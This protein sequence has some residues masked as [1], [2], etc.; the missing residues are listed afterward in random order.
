MNT[1]NLIHATVA[2]VSL[3]LSAAEPSPFIGCCADLTTDEFNDRE[4]T[5]EM[6]TRAGIGIV[7]TGFD[8]REAPVRDGRRD[9][10]RWD[11][12]LES[13]RRARMEILAVLDGPKTLT[14]GDVSAAWRTFVRET[15]THFKGQISA[16]EVWNEPNIE[17]FWHENFACIV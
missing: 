7:R 6:A 11:A 5:L 17:T 13:A 2:A 8:M 3:M 16:W 14:T 9:F 10:A 15:V 1:H 4:R 12:V